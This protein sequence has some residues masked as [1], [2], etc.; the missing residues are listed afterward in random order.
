M[1]KIKLGYQMHQAISMR[2]LTWY[3]W[4]GAEILYEMSPTQAHKPIG[5]RG[6]IQICEHD[7]HSE[8]Q[9]PSDAHY[10][11]AYAWKKGYNDRTMTKDEWKAQWAHY[12]KYMNPEPTPDMPL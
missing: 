1:K 8:H 7:G 2:E 10:V 11:L 9:P 6:S 5:F 12:R 3:D 4:M